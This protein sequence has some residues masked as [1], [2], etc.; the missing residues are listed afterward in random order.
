MFRG[1][2]SERVAFETAFPRT[3]GTD[4]LTDSV[5]PEP[6]FGERNIRAGVEP[7][8]KRYSHPPLKP[9]QNVR[10]EIFRRDNLSTEPIIVI[11]IFEA[12]PKAPPKVFLWVSLFWFRFQPTVTKDNLGLKL[13]PLPLPPSLFK[14]TNDPQAICRERRQSSGN[15]AETSALRLVR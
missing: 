9:T 7:H 10:L 8:M 15:G 14:E 12:Y 11:I 13:G 2:C 1:S 5:E 6:F 3:T 4:F